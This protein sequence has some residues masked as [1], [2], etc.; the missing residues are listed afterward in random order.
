MS[1]GYSRAVKLIVLYGPPG[2]GKLTV[3][4][5]LAGRTGYRLFHNHLTVDL[6]ASLFDHGSPEYLNYVQHLRREAFERAATAG[7]NLVFTFWYSR[8]SSP[9]VERYQAIVEAHGGEVVFVRL[10]CR[11]EV[12][13]ARVVSAS[14]QNWKIASVPALREALEACP[15]SFASIPGTRLELDISDLA[16]EEAAGQ[17]AE[18]LGL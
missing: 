2:T 7:V 17:I 8:V 10:W 4:R 14:R 5:V 13:E 12:L 1:P 16:P 18:R 11:P 9:S 3:A 15:D 6:A